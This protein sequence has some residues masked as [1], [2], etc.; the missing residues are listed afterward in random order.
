MKGTY[1]IITGMVILDFSWNTP[2]PKATIW[3]II[4]GI[5]VLAGFIYCMYLIMYPVKCPNCGTENYKDMGECKKCKQPLVG[6]P[7]S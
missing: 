6:N 7:S 3:N 2:I 1:A 5:L 4:G